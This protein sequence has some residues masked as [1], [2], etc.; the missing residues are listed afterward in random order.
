MDTESF[1]HV[2][3]SDDFIKVEETL[4]DHNPTILE[5]DQTDSTTPKL[6]I[7]GRDNIE[8]LREIEKHRDEMIAKGINLDAIVEALDHADISP[9]DGWPD[10]IPFQRLMEDMKEDYLRPKNFVENWTPGQ[11][12]PMKRGKKRR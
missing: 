2:T 11:G 8:I 9:K 7:V 4:I 6:L 10:P 1:H 5:V 12:A 3:S